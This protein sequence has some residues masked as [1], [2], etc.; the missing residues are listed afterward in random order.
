MQRRENDFRFTNFPLL[1]RTWEPAGN[2]RLVVQSILTSDRDGPTNNFWSATGMVSAAPLL[3]LYSSSTAARSLTAL[4]TCSP[5]MPLL[6]TSPAPSSTDPST[7]STILAQFLDSFSAAPQQLLYSSSG[8][9]QLL[10][11]SSL[12]GSTPKSH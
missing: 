9:L 6:G 2:R 4:Y 3:P 5:S 10:Y 7:S 12:S 8:T 1:F 11:S